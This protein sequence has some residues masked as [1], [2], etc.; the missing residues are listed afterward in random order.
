MKLLSV[1]LLLLFASPLHAQLT[2]TA[3]PK[4]GT[5]T[6]TDPRTHFTF[7][8][9]FPARIERVQHTT[10]HDAIGP[11]HAL[12]FRW[13]LN[14]DP[15]HAEIRTYDA[16][17]VALFRVILPHAVY[18]NDP[19]AF[20]DFTT[21]PRDLHLFSYA[22]Q[23]F[24]PPQFSV[25]QISAPWLLFDDHLNAAILSPANHFQVLTMRGDGRTRTAVSTGLELHDL[26]ANF[27]FTSLLVI[28][29]GIHRAF[30]T[31]GDA[32]THLTG[33]QRPSNEADA[34]LK[35]LGYWT[36]NG[37]SY[38][39]NFDPKR[40]YAGT[41][42]AE[43]NRLR[44]AK[45]PVG[46]LQLDS[47]W[48]EKDSISYDGTPLEAKESKF[49]PARWN[50]YGGIWSYTAS[51]DLFPNG[52]AAFQKQ[53]ALPLVVH[54][55]WMSQR[56][57]YHQKYEIAGVAPLDPRYW[58]E[59]ATYLH[60]NGVVTYEQDWLDRIRNFSD[61]EKHLD[62][63]DQFF[64]NMAA[65]MAK[66]GLTMQYCMATPS[67]FLEAARFS[68]LTTIRTSGDHF[69]RAQRLPFLYV[70]EL[71]EAVGAWPWADV[72]DSPDRDAILL[73][74]L[75]AGPVGF[76]DAL[77]HENR[78][79]LLRAVRSDGVIIKPDAPIV[80][81]D[82]SYLDAAQRKHAPT[83]AATY[84]NH[85]GL[86]TAYLYAFAPTPADRG[87]VEFT[88]ADVGLSGGIFV[89]DVFANRGEPVAAGKTF[90][91][92]LRADDSA[93]YIAAPIVA[94]TAF[95]GDENAYVGTGKMRVAILHP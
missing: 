10:G 37:A 3:D 76:G 65:A 59:I 55:R 44:D 57:P 60:A 87:P 40:G 82:R 29:P 67:D 52:L 39:Y 15:V 38:Y 69:V 33:K 8:G 94:G 61:F 71:A 77:G 14:A 43:L 11:Y 62:R 56:S 12:H 23:N 7:S 6:L 46:Y 49:P 83:L 27:E 28:E 20:P 85:S 34:T 50:I 95:L 41:L 17:P 1:L 84:T 51:P 78:S 42:L 16:K 48:Y 36:D 19:I 91:S 24:A 26:P 74:T 5:Y 93:F 25:S 32:L 45:I 80:P 72:A 79:N 18:L 31:W 73:Q 75:S 70:S 90:T 35:Y 30:R 86:R 64:T 2:A 63:G 53:V 13:T 54:S 66:Q 21:Q 47:W 4:S 68:N 92:A 22:D 9:T 88:A 58:N 81:L 89:Y